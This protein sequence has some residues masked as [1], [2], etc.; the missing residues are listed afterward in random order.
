MTFFLFLLEGLFFIVLQ[1]TLLQTLPAWM[2]APPDLLF[3]L[4]IF[5]AVHVD[6]VPGLVLAL[7]FGFCMDLVSGLYLGVYAAIYLLLFLLIKAISGKLALQYLQ[8]RPALTAL[9]YLLAQGAVFLLNRVLAEQDMLAWSWRQILL[10]T[11]LVAIFSIPCSQLF[12]LTKALS[13]PQR[14]KKQDRHSIAPGP[15]S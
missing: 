8:H 15:I 2:G 3:I 4:L 14:R 9:S 11:L 12:F 10:G 13:Q 7:F 5:C 6:A 1:T